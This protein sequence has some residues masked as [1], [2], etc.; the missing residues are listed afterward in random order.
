MTNSNWCTHSVGLLKLSNQTNPT[1]TR[2]R[3]NKQKAHTF[4]KYLENIFLP[5]AEQTEIKDQIGPATEIEGIILNTSRDIFR[6][7]K[8]SRIRPNY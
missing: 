3:D 6:E 2:A 5:H 7:I 4:E 8:K 1:S